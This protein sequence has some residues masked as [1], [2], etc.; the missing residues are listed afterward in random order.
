MSVFS[1]LLLT[2]K[3]T[4]LLGSSTSAGKQPEREEK[5]DAMKRYLRKNR[6]AHF[7]QYKEE[8]WTETKNEMKFSDL[9]YE[10]EVYRCF[11]IIF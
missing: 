3:V 1:T 7:N 4:E 11:W 8:N 6:R 2:R 9:K 5:V 10:N